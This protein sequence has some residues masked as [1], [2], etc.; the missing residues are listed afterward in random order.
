MTSHRRIGSILS[1]IAA[2][3]AL[4]A[5]AAPSRA[6]DL[7]ALIAAT[8]RDT[9]GPAMGVVVI[10]DGVVA[11]ETVRGVRR[12]DGADPVTLEDDW[13]VGSDGK[14]MTATLVA[15]LVDKGVLSWSTPLDKMLPDLA[16]AMHP[17]YRKVTLLQLL[18]HHAGLPEN[19]MD[20]KALA[21]MLAPAPGTPLPARR[22]TY[23]ARALKDPP[24]GPTSA[25][26]YSNTGVL[27]AG[28]IAERSTGAP[29]EALIRR[30]VFAP[31]GMTHV[32]FG[33]PPAG[34]PI[35]HMAGKP[36]APADENPDF[37]APD[38][39][40]YMPLDEWALF[41]LDQLAGAKGKGRLLKPE[42]Y[43]LMQTAQPGGSGG[44]G[45]GVQETIAGRK[46]PVLIHA[47]S[48][49]AW[50]ALVALFPETGGGVLIAANAGP[51]MGADKA[52]K[53]VMKPILDTLAPPAAP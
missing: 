39:N 35:G 46:G 40:M 16:G 20:E 36:A 25:F 51:D 29:F 31:L 7:N 44:L 8:M 50:Y 26:S 24:I 41:C 33:L 6:E 32:G 18:S 15:R 27:I 11:G 23:V 21:A 22:L 43:R 52:E 1:A 19:I 3:V 10:R 4:G 49:G 47:G 14:P 2:A 37:L 13:H 34:Q 38:G 12:N 30:E 53:A 28:V 45:W 42:T 9:A 17:E 5:G 48:D